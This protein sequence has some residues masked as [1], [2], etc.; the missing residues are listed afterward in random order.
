MNRQQTVREALRRG[1]TVTP[2]G[3]GCTPSQLRDTVS[4]IRSAKYCGKGQL[5]LNVVLDKTAGGYRLF[6]PARDGGAA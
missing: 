2:S 3:M 6:D 5:P 1:E 4:V